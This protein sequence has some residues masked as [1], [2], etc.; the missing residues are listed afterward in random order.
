LKRVGTPGDVARVVRFL[1]SDEAGF[2]T[3]QVLA[4][5]GG[6]AIGRYPRQEAIHADA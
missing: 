3:G 4:V 6:W 1:A 5:D 2:M